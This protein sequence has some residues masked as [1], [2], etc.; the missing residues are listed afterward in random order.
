MNVE[1]F[2]YI[3]GMVYVVLSSSLFEQHEQQPALNGCQFRSSSVVFAVIII[4]RAHFVNAISTVFL[5]GY[6]VVT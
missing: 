1:A 4:I 3:N 2:T 5:C 6:I